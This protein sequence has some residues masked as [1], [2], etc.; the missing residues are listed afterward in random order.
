MFTDAA[1]WGTTAWKYQLHS[2]PSLHHLLAWIVHF[3]TEDPLPTYY[4]Q[5]PPCSGLTEPS[6]LI[7]AGPIAQWS[8]ASWAHWGL[9]IP[10][11]A[12]C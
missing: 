11:S 6:V 7:R 3:C 5:L 2:S 8:E 1:F 4:E 9:N 10:H 12:R